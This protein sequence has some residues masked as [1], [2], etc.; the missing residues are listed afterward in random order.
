MQATLARELG[1]NED[2]AA[3]NRQLNEALASAKVLASQPSP[4]AIALEDARIQ[5]SQT[6]SAWDAERKALIAS[7][8]DLTRS[9]AS[10]ETDRDFFRDQYAQASMYVDSVRK[11]NTEFE[12]RV[13]VAEGKAKD[14]VAMIKAT[15]DG[16]LK[17]LE[18][19]VARWKGLAELLQEKDRRTGDEVRRRAGEEP[20]LRTKNAALKDEIDRLTGVVLD[21]SRECEDLHLYLSEFRDECRE[22]SRWRKYR[23]GSF[24]EWRAHIPW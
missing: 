14:G 24:A 12:E 13:L 4:D 21:L 5:W 6:R 10:A 3:T 18:M 8:D 17:A 22:T 11:E 2:L 1:R 7:M 16:R 9:K 23:G 15:Y 19:D 20:E